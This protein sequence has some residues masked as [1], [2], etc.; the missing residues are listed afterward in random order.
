MSV[1]SS[2]KRNETGNPPVLLSFLVDPDDRILSF[3][4]RLAVVAMMNLAGL[5]FRRPFATPSS[6]FMI[7]SR[8]IFSVMISY[9]L[10]LHP[11]IS[12]AQL[13]W[14]S[15]HID[16]MLFLPRPPIALGIRILPAPAEEIP[17]DIFEFVPVLWFWIDPGRRSWHRFSSTY[18]LLIKEPL[19]KSNMM[20]RLY[21][22]S[23]I[24]R[25]VPPLR[26]SHHLFN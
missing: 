26:E 19:Y 15:K 2:Q 17:D 5:N 12:P 8:I 23:P 10:A 6:T 25:R 3:T 18:E 4:S 13:L 20:D 24:R 14:P 21:S 11:H 1:R 16:A 22:K 7:S 9:P